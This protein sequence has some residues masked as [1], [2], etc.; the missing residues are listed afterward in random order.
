MLNFVIYNEEELKIFLKN[1]FYKKSIKNDTIFQNP[2]WILECKKIYLNNKNTRFFFIIVKKKNVPLLLL[3]LYLQEILGSK[4]LKFISSESLDK[5]NIIFFSENI[6]LNK[7]ELNNIWMEIIKEI[8]PDL[9]YL[10]KILE[11]NKQKFNFFSGKNYI[12]I[13]KNFI[14]KTSNTTFDNFYKS[15]NSSKTINTDKRKL[16]KLSKAGVIKYKTTFLNYSNLN[17]LKKLID[18]KSFSYVEKNQ[19][20]FNNKKLYNFYS[21]IIKNKISKF[22]IF[23]M[24]LNSK[25]HIIYFW[26]F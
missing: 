7:S 14:L 12:I 19:K 3:P 25:N 26:C 16:K 6:D 4:I 5:N 18:D 11:I 8:K 20:T 24:N 15:K 22:V 2:S 13:N 21:N 17:I 10:E 1:K 9:I 23:D